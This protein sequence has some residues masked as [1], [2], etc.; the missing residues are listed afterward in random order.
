LRLLL[1]KFL[2]EDVSVKKGTHYRGRRG[3]EGRN[4]IMQDILTISIGGQRGF[5]QIHFKMKG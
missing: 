4:W 2:R 1:Q 3:K 5:L